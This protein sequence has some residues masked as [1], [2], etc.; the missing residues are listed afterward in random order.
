VRRVW[1]KG[2]GKLSC[3]FWESREKGNGRF[4]C[5]ISLTFFFKFFG[6]PVPAGGAGGDLTRIWSTKLCEEERA[7]QAKTPR[8]CVPDGRDDGLCWLCDLGNGRAD[9]RARA[10]R[11][12]R[13]IYIYLSHTQQGNYTIMP[14]FSPSPVPYVYAPV[15]WLDLWKTVTSLSVGANR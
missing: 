15:C 11:W 7:K 8:E 9:Q 3:V 2:R 13:G 1:W 5:F 12:Q 14:F 4:D 10:F 6:N